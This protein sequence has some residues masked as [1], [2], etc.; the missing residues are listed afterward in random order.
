MNKREISVNTPPKGSVNGGYAVGTTK[1][2]LICF[3]L[4]QLYKMQQIGVAG[5]QKQWLFPV[6]LSKC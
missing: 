1:I 6:W 4:F 3:Q 5:T 2:Q